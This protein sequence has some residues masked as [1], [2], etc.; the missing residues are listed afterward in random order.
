MPDDANTTV[1]AVISAPGG[2]ESVYIEIEGGNDMFDLIAE[3]QL[4]GGKFELVDCPN[5]TVKDALVD[6]NVEIPT[7]GLTSY[8][9]PISALFSLLD[10]NSMGATT[11]TEGH[12]FHVKV[13]DT[14][15]GETESQVSIIVRESK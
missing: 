12:V 13:K 15:Y 8:T 14:V 1:N 3:A 9:F 10:A 6:M 5:Q 7:K 4:G 11:T 2:L